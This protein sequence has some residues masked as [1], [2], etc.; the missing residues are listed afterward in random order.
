MGLKDAAG[1]LAESIV[2]GGLFLV[3]PVPLPTVYKKKNYG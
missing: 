1:E 3:R 2:V